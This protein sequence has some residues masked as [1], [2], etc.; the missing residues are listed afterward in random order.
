L[1]L[2]IALNTNNSTRHITSIA[3]S[4][5][6]VVVIVVTGLNRVPDKDW[7]LRQK[8]EPRPRTSE[9]G[10]LVV[11]TGNFLHEHHDLAPQGGIINSLERFNQP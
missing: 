2:C 5:I 3:T 11:V 7:S 10:I 9:P 1:A 6:L 8:R 4:D